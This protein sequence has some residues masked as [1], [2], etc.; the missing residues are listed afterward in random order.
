MNAALKGERICS[1][2]GYSGRRGVNFSPEPIT[3]CPQID[4][5]LAS[6]EP[7][8]VGGCDHNNRQVLGGIHTLSP[9]VY[10]GGLERQ[11]KRR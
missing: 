9:G 6:R 4:D 10:C 1:A 2:G 8:F 5:P 3:D 7:P 11:E